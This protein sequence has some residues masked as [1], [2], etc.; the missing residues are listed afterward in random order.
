MRYGPSDQFRCQACLYTRRTLCGRLKLVVVLT[1]VLSLAGASLASA[2]AAPRVPRVPQQFIGMN[3]DSPFFDTGVNQDRQFKVMVASGVESV[4]V[5]FNW[6]AAQPTKGGPISFT[7]TDA[8]VMLAAKHGMTVLPTVIYAPDWDAAPHR[9]DHLAIPKSNGPY[10]D[11]VQAL[12]ERY[13]PDGSFWTENPSLRPRPIRAWQIWNE[14]DSSYYWSK[15]PFARSYLKLVR[16][17]RR[18]IRTVDPQGKVVLAGMPGAEWDYLTEVYKVKGARS[19]FDV[20]AAHAYTML[21]VNV[22]RF[23]QNVRQ[24]MTRY[25]DRNKPIVVTESGWASSVGKVFDVP[26]CCQTTTRDQARYITALLPLLATN[27]RAL[28]LIGYY[29]FTWVGDE[30]FGAPYFNFSGLFRL[31]NHGFVAKPAFHA[32]RTGALAVEHCRSKHQIA[33]RCARAS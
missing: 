19:L 9:S 24:V 22:I 12:V 29:Y 18:A 15:Q 8:I 14:P 26:Y 27:W 1:V 28:G 10:A 4:R 7:T 17:A 13:G 31:T 20:V 32:F 2:G 23:V 21:P 25:G 33:S 5:A 16:A 30:Y 6:S 11:Y 3:L